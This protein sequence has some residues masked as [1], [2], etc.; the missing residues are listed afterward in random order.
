MLLLYI[1]LTALGLFVIARGMTW[2]LERITF[3]AIT[4]HFRAA[5]YILAHHKAPPDWRKSSPIFWIGLGAPARRRK[6]RLI[7]RLDALISYFETSPLVKD[8]ETRSVLLER[9]RDERIQWIVHSLDEI[10]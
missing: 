6:E 5:E 8:E 9:L 10:I 1:L 2:Y 4:R 3:N 7:A